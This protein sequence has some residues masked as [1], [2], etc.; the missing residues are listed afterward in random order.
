MASVSAAEMAPGHADR[1]RHARAV[2]AMAMTAFT[3]RAPP[4]G[5]ASNGDE[6]DNEQCP[7]TAIPGGGGRR[8]RHLRRMPIALRNSPAT[9]DEAADLAPA[10]DRCVLRALALAQWASSTADHS[11]P[12]PGE[13]PSEQWPLPPRKPN[14]VAAA[15]VA[16]QQ[17]ALSWAALVG[18]GPP[19]PPSMSQPPPSTPL[20]GVLAEPERTHLRA[21]EETVRALVTTAATA[22]AA[23]VKAGLVPAPCAKPPTPAGAVS[24][25][26]TQQGA[27]P[28]SAPAPTHAPSP[29]AAVPPLRPLPATAPAALTPVRALSPPATTTSR[30]RG[31]ARRGT[32][33]PVSPAPALPT[34]LPPLPPLQRPRFACPTAHTPVPSAPG[35]PAPSSPTAMS[36][37][38]ALVPDAAAARAREAAVRRAAALS[39]LMLATL[40]MGGRAIPP[41]PTLRVAPALTTPAHFFPATPHDAAAAATSAKAAPLPSFSVPAR[42]PISPDRTE[43][44][45]TEPSSEGGEHPG[46]GFVPSGSSGEEEE[47]LSTGAPSRRWQPR[48]ISTSTSSSSEEA[49]GGAAPGE[50]ENFVVEIAGA[51]ESGEEEEEE[52]VAPEEAGDNEGAAIEDAVAVA[53]GSASGA[54]TRESPGAHGYRPSAA[55]AASGGAPPAPHAPPTRARARAQPAWNFGKGEVTGMSQPLITLA[56]TLRAFVESPRVR[57]VMPC[58][59]PFSRPTPHPLS[60]SLPHTHTHDFKAA[61]LL[62]ARFTP[63]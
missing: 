26:L 36:I 15:A 47:A 7:S 25:S 32:R 13:G 14:N 11:T 34:P 21:C 4:I 38:S 37:P 18:S 5:A 24:T 62:Q 53:A 49:F 60:V 45:S 12:L 9:R 42:G 1:R 51:S 28:V 57:S 63:P 6:I 35:V 52:E 3:F 48:G 23:A 39:P 27:I 40:I 55:T 43:P 59:R 44:S 54:A 61:R 50:D 58:A 10:G 31:G 8:A 41:P 46:L 19:R 33:V 29:A 20:P 16:H 30:A 17:P 22:R 2:D 56:L